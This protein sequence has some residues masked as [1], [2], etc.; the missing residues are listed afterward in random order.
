Y[1]VSFQR[2]ASIARCLRLVKPAHCLPPHKSIHR[3]TVGSSSLTGCALMKRFVG[4][5]L[6]LSLSFFIVAR[7]AKPSH[8]PAAAARNTQRKATGQANAEALLNDASR[9]LAAMIKDARA[10]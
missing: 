6:C 1:A 10:E 3:F 4:L 7:A 5:L 2:R 8:T 9:A